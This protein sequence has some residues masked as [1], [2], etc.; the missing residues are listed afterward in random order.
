M[1]IYTSRE[2]CD[3]KTSQ[4]SASAKSRAIISISLASSNRGILLSKSVPAVSR[5]GL[6]GFYGLKFS[7]VTSNIF[8]LFT[9]IKHKM[10]IELSPEP[11]AISRDKSIKPN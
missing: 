1:T 3:I 4:I 11:R 7:L 8:R 5:P 9:R 10:L 6:F 2:R